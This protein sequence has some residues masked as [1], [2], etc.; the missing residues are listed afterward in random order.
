MRA[1]S[2]LLIT[3]PRRLAPRASSWRTDAATSLREVR[4]PQ[5]TSRTP[6]VMDAITADSDTANVGGASKTTRS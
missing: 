6:S 3:K 2:R 5:M 1:R 4:P